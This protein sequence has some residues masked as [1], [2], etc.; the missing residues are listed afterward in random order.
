MKGRP[1]LLCFS[2]VLIYLT[3][4]FSQD[5]V[6]SRD[7]AIIL[8]QKNFRLQSPRAVPADTLVKID[9]GYFATE[10]D[11]L[12]LTSGDKGC[13][14]SIKVAIGVLLDNLEVCDSSI[15]NFTGITN[16]TYP[17]WLNSKSD[18]MIRFWLKNDLDD[19]VT[20]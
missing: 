4:G 15:V 3:P 18:R 13:N 10:R 19:S 9:T 11:S 7:Q 1:L 6:L 16:E 17:L 5:I 14:D 8:L 12:F 2:I 20:V